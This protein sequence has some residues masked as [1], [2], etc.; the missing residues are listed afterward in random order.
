MRCSEE[1][2]EVKCNWIDCFGG[3]GLSGRGI[4]SHQGDFT[5]KDCKEFKTVGDFFKVKGIKPIKIME[6]A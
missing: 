2:T 5:D 4:C 6:G 1:M 3:L